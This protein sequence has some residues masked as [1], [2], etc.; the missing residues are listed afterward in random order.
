MILSNLDILKA[1]D[2]ADLSIAPLAARN[3]DQPPFN[4]S[5][6]D[7]RLGPTIMI[8]RPGPYIHSLQ[9]AYDPEFMRRNCEIVSLEQQPTYRLQPNT[10]IL[11][12]TLE[13]VAL[14]IRAGRP[15]YAARVEGR[16]S[17]ARLGLLVHFTAPTIHSGFNGTITLEIINLGPNPIELVRGV[18]ICQLIVESVS[19]APV[20]APNQFRGQQSPEGRAD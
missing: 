7:L 1:I 18:Y 2:A 4:T 3:P 11:A 12:Q 9:T 19:T 8:P 6:V 15:L 13:S 20:P 16:S 10:F 5:S 14:P 17:R